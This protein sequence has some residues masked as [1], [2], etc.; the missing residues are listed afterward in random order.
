MYIIINIF[1][2]EVDG[3][4]TLDDFFN[5][6]STSISGFE[7]KEQSTSISEFNEEERTERY[8][9]DDWFESLSDADLSVLEGNDE[10]EESNDTII[11]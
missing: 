8:I 2:Q 3:Q 6:Q 4:L 5:E 1:I 10:D 11:Y 9:E 7:E